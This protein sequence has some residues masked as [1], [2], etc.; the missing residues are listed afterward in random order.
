MQA[1]IYTCQFQQYFCF[2]EIK[3]RVGYADS[4]PNFQII[5]VWNTVNRAPVRGIVGET[6]LPF[7]PD[8]WDHLDGFLSVW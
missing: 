4:S 7:P 6:N 2:K 8:G 1:C 3:P 5:I